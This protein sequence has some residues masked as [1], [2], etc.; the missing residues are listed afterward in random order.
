[1]KQK[2]KT[3]SLRLRVFSLRSISCRH[4]ASWLHPQVHRKST[5]PHAVGWIGASQQEG[6]RDCGASDAG[7]CEEKRMSFM[8]MNFMR[9]EPNSDDCQPNREDM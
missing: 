8:R 7:D 3:K 9:K 1:M 5:G 4:F 2:R 6:E